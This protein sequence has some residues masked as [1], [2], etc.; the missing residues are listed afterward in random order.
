MV[1]VGQGELRRAAGRAATEDAGEAAL[2]HLARI[3]HAGIQPERGC[4]GVHHGGHFHREPER[5]P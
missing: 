5:L 2:E 4:G 3:F 1:I